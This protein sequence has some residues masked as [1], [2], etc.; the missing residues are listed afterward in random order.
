MEPSAN[1]VLQLVDLRE[2]LATSIGVNISVPD[3][4]AFTEKIGKPFVSKLKANISS[5]FG[6][7]D[8]TAAFSIFDPKKVPSIDSADIKTYGE[9]FINTLHAHFGVPKA[10]KTLEG[11]EC[12]KEPIVLD[13]TMI[14]WKNYRCFLA[15][16]PKEKITTQLQELATND[17]MGAMYP[18]LK[19]LVTIC[20]TMPVTT[21]SV[22][23]SFSQMKLIKSRLRNR[24]SDLSLSHL[25]VEQTVNIWNRKPRKI[26][27]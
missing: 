18:S 20:L 2:E 23:R 21:A 11:V 22:K 26:A 16:N 5:R 25:K 9:S 24:L 27:A 6:S 1:W 7:Q 14:E 15:Q 19:A 17:M 8:I 4:V 13:E 12:T 10:V 3:I